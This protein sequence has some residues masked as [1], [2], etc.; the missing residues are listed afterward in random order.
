MLPNPELVF[1]LYVNK[2]NHPSH[3]KNHKFGVL[4]GQDCT[5]PTY[6][7]TIVSGNPYQPP[8]S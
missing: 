3:S 1:T 4:S 2:G 5:R 6:D 8:V 7:V